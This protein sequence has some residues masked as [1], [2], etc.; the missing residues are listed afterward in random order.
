MARTQQHLTSVWSDKYIGRVTFIL[1][2]CALIGILNHSNN[3]SIYCIPAVPELLHYPIH[4]SQTSQ[5]Q[6]LDEASTGQ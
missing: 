4:S 5:I 6:F 3:H 1:A 2:M